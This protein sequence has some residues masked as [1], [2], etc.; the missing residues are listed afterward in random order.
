[1]VEARKLENAEEV[2][3]VTVS[4]KEEGRKEGRK[5]GLKKGK[6]EVA[7]KMLDEG[8]EIEK[9]AELTGLDKNEIEKLKK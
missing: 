5:E 7:F 2:F 4:Y 6:M 9:I 8:F 1:M 3:E